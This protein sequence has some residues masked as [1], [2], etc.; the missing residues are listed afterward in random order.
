MKR[1]DDALDMY[2]LAYKQDKENPKIVYNIGCIFFLKDN[3]K[4]GIEWFNRGMKIDK[5]ALISQMVRDGDLKK[6]KNNEEFTEFLQN[7]REETFSE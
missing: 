1:Y 7:I 3:V 2:R 6:I 5:T 4:E